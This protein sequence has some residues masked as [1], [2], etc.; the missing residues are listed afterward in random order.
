MQIGYYLVDQCDML[1]NV[2]FNY[3]KTQRLSFVMCA[4]KEISC[5]FA[6]SQVREISSMMF[7]VVLPLHLISNLENI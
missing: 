4:I 2:T 5:L 7:F 1:C 6:L 3:A